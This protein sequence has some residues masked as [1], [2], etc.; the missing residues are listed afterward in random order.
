MG[1]TS[2]ESPSAINFLTSGYNGNQG[3]PIGIADY[4]IW[5]YTNN[6]SGNYSSWQHVRSTGT[7]LAGQGFTMKGVTDTDDS[8]EEKTK[9]CLWRQTK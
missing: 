2:S 8:V 5:K 3:N 7:L 4:W 9:L 1:W 6:L